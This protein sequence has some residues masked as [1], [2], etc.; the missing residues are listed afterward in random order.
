MSDASSTSTVRPAVRTPDAFSSSHPLPNSL[1]SLSSSRHSSSSSHVSKTY[2][3]ASTLFLTRRLPEALSTI[4]PVIQSSTG[5]DDPAD[6]A[7]VARASRSTRVKVW[8]LYLT[9]LNAIVELDPDE[10]KEAFG[11]QDWRALCSKV[12]DGEVWDEVV[13]YGYHG[14]EGDLDP[15]VVVNLATLLLAHSRTQHL[16]QKRL[17]N[18][19]AASLA[20][21]LDL[22]NRFSESP[23]P[24]GRFH[25]RHRSPAKR[26]GGTDT[27]QDLNS[28]VKILELYT[29]HVLP[30]NEEWDYA[31]EFISMSSILDDERREAFLQALQSLQD[32]Q[33]KAERREAEARREEEER[34]R[35]EIEEA[36]RLRAKNEERERKRLEEQ[37][38]LRDGSEVD[39]G[40]EKTP[41]IAGSSKGS[42]TNRPNPGTAPG[43]PAPKGGLARPRGKT[44]TSVPTFGTRA[45]MV[46][47]RLAGLMEQLRASFRTNPLLLM[48]L[49]A[50]VLGLLLVLG[51]KNIRER[52]QR[53]IKTGWDKIK[54]TA[55]MG[56]KVSYM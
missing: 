31:R 49:L 38:A 8:T 16:N 12:K 13:R 37:R 34:Q 42:K 1:S 24:S 35:R 43:P 48:R 54:A 46:M 52:A 26:T 45:T 40:V 51:Q 6:P 41:S 4:L 29:L 23:N 27:P 14:V 36:R 22:T 28:R 17:E 47:S 32:D 56:V 10:G 21:N 30:R 25:S 33:E 9:I 3:Q 39:Y 5:T 44:T 18:Y 7:P 53:V 20:P 2:K 15:D 50:F 11:G 19:L 55:G